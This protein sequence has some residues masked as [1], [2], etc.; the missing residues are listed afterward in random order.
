[1]RP[2]PNCRRLFDLFNPPA[3]V[4]LEYR[5]K[6]HVGNY[7]MQEIYF[8]ARKSAAINVTKESSGEGAVLEIRT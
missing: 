7:K 5:G 3:S 4:S 8:T 6:L 2:G 1:M